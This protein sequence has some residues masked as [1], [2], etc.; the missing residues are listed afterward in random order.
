V[1]PDAGARPEESTPISPARSGVSGPPTS[2]DT[3]AEPGEGPTKQEPTLA[4]RAS[5][6]IRTVYGPR[7]S[8]STTLNP[9]CA[10]GEP[11][12]SCVMQAASAAC[13]WPLLGAVGDALHPANARCVSGPRLR[14]R[15]TATTATAAAA[16]PS[17]AVLRLRCRCPRVCSA[18]SPACASGDAFSKQRDRF[19]FHPGLLRPES[20]RVCEP[21][22]RAEQFVDPVRLL[23]AKR[24]QQCVDL[25]TH[26]VS[27]VDEIDRP[28]ARP[29]PVGSRCARP[30][31]V[32]C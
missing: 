18:P 21:A 24:C 5:W 27:S 20:L 7:V 3:S 1:A 6:R 32:A 11:V 9:L 13:T 29:S 15:V 8:V 14:M 16:A 30:A 22:R 4:V 17:A 25:V 31:I 28:A 26:T 2:S 12:G 23:G 19:S 10:A